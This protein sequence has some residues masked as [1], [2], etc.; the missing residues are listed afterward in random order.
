MSRD[1][2]HS[3]VTRM[4]CAQLLLLMCLFVD[5]EANQI[6]ALMTKEQEYAR[7]KHTGAATKQY[8]VQFAQ[9]RENKIPQC[10]RIECR[11]FT[12]AF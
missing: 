10:L 4:S 7:Q 5:E 3:H 11:G 2:P 9:T 12:S 6:E 1:S 8:F